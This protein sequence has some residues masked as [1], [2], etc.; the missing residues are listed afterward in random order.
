LTYYH[1]AIFS[2]SLIDSLKDLDAKHIRRESLNVWRQAWLDIAKTYPD[3]ELATRIYDVGVRYKIDEDRN[4][5]Y[6]LIATER[7]IAEQ[8]LGLVEK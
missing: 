7:L 8:A 6:D 5:L 3:L 2:V 4:V 1:N